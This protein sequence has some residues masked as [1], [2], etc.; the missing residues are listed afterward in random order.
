MVKFHG[1]KNLKGLNK[2]CLN[3]DDKFQAFKWHTTWFEWKNSM[4]QGVNYN[5]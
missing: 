5:V 2:K 1:L 3:S 4:V